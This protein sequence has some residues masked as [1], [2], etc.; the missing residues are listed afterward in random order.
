[1]SLGGATEA[2]IWS[3]YYEIGEVKPAWKS[4][5]L[6]HAFKKSD[7]VCLNFAGE[8]CPMDVVGE[9][10]IGG[11]GVA[12]GYCGDTEKTESCIYST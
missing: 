8:L 10:Y 5:T 7:N 4:I 11:V 3:I 9:I 12:Q 2:S 6:W 1:M